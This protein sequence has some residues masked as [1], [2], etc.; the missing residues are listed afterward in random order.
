MMFHTTIC[1]GCGKPVPVDLGICVLCGDQLH[2]VHVVRVS[3]PAPTFV[4]HSV[5]LI[6][7]G[8]LAAA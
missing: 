1:Q 5:K 4:I 7:E 3:K 2:A 8:E 6:M